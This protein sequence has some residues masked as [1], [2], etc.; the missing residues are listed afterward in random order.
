MT[1]RE[2]IVSLVIHLWFH[3]DYWTFWCSGVPPHMDM[4]TDADSWAVLTMVKGIP[5]D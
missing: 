1:D 2:Y 4:V 3:G 5:N